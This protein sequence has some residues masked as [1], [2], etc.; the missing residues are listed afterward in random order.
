MQNVIEVCIGCLQ[1]TESDIKSFKDILKVEGRILTSTE[2]DLS[3]YNT[4]W[5]R[6]VRGWS[7]HQSCYKQLITLCC[8]PILCTA[9]AGSSFHKLS[10]PAH[11][12]G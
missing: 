6:T 1:I 12:A 11:K 10:G 7:T 8:N 5:L 3:A 9:P 4:D 2:D